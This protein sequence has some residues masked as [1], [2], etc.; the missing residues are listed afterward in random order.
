MRTPR[1]LNASVETP[2]GWIRP[3]R[4]LSVK[5]D[6]STTH[7]LVTVLQPQSGTSPVGEPRIE[8]RPDRVSVAIGPS[9]VTWRRT[10][11]G[12]QVDRP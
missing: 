6:P 1:G 5:A 10:A 9:R 2:T 3:V 7:A 11:S 12:W 8:Q 4:V